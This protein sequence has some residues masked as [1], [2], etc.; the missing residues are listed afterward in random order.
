MFALT[1]VLYLGKAHITWTNG[2]YQ[3]KIRQYAKYAVWWPVRCVISFTVCKHN[4]MFSMPYVV[5][6]PCA[7]HTD[8]QC[9]ATCNELSH[10]DNLLACDCSR[11]TSP[12]SLALERMEGNL[13][14]LNLNAFK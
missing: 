7:V 5:P 9:F 6:L 13:N 1:L 3:T 14:F 4:C 12:L 11:M 10:C 2:K 8:E